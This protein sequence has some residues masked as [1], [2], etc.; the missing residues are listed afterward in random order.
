MREL[1]LEQIESYGSEVQLDISQTISK[2]LKDTRCINL[3]QTGDYLAEL[4]STADD[5]TKL[6]TVTKPYWGF[7]VG[8]NIYI[9]KSNL[10]SKTCVGIYKTEDLSSVVVTTWDIEMLNECLKFE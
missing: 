8:E 4:S 2:L 5:I 7:K 1:S 3:G 10:T 6:V 9:R